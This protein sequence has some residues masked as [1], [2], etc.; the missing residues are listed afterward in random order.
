MFYLLDPP[1]AVRQLFL[2]PEFAAARGTARSGKPGTWEASPHYKRLNAATGGEMSKRLNSAWE[3]GA[4]GVQ[5]TLSRKDTTSVFI[6]RS[7]TVAARQD[8]CS[9]VLSFPQPACSAHCIV[10]KDCS[11][12]A[13]DL[14]RRITL[15]AFSAV[16]LV[17]APPLTWATHAAG[18]QVP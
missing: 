14:R 7:V 15:H 8:T 16:I 2:M 18:M 3:L 1:G 9:C 10:S 13:P 4:D 12:A 5:L 11:L 17:I 6:L